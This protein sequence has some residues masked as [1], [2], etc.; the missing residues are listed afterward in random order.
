[1]SYAE[2]GIS[3][4]LI[5]GLSAL[6]GTALA[7]RLGVLLG[8]RDPR[9]LTRLPALGVAIALPFLLGVSLIP[10]PFW[11]IACAVPAGLTAAGWA[12]LVYTVV[13]NLVPASMRAVAA[14]VL[15]FFITLLGMGAGPLA[16]GALS[17]AFASGYGDQSLQMAMVV[18][19]ISSAVGAVVIFAAGRSLR[20]EMAL[21][22]AG[23][24]S[25]GA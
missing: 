18:V 7:G 20:T 21:T 2:I 9:W 17:D 22:Q 10:D 8:E 12:P 19:L 23:P 6:A 14:S 4:G 15:I 1:M 25:A 24:K 13:Q 11:A 3:F 5:S 16:V